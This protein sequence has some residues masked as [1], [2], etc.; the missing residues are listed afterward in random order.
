[1]WSAPGFV[2]DGAFFREVRQRTAVEER[3]DFFE[4]LHQA[5]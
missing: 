5:E 1:L 3:R 4:S 2:E